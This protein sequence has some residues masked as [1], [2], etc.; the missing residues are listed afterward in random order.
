MV[1]GRCVIVVFPDHTHLF[2]LYFSQEICLRQVCLFACLLWRKIKIHATFSRNYSPLH[3]IKYILPIR[4][5]HLR[6][7]SKYFFDVLLLSRMIEVR[8]V[9]LIPVGADSMLNLSITTPWYLSFC[10][11]IP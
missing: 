5:L 3:R 2:F 10:Y 4:H 1:C 6:F 7:S 9:Y 8:Y 11:P